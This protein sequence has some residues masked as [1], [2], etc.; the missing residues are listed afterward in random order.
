MARGHVIVDKA[1]DGTYTVPVTINAT[2][3]VVDR[4]LL[5]GNPT[6]IIDVIQQLLTVR[7]ADAIAYASQLLTDFQAD[8]ST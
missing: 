4:A 8:L 3:H 6:A 7:E 1:A 2:V 5:A